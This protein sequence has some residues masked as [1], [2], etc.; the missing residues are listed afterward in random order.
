MSI[1]PI[2]D[3]IEQLSV[4]CYNE[5]NN[6]LRMVGMSSLYE[7]IYDY[8]LN[9]IKE[10]DIK[11]GDKIPTEEEL[12][13]QFQ[14]SRITSKKA[15]DLLSQRDIIQRFQGKGSFVSKNL[16]NF[17]STSSSESTEIKPDAYRKVIGFIIPDFTDTYGLDLVRAIEKRC[18]EL[19]YNLVLKRTFGLEEEEKKAIHSLL[20]IGV[21]GIIILP[22]Q[23]VHYNN[24]LL[25]MVV[26]EYP[27]VLI[28]RYLKR[29]PATSVS[30]DNR[31]AMQELTTLSLDSGH[32]NIAFISPSVDGTSS[33]EERFRGYQAAFSEKGK[34]INQEHVLTE[35]HSTM[36]VHVYSENHNIS[37]EKDRERL[38]QFIQHHPEVTAYVCSEFEIAMLLNELLT[39]MGKK[40]PDD[41]SILCFDSPTFYL[42]EPFFTHIRQDQEAM[43]YQAADL[44]IKQLN[45]ERE[46]HDCK[47]GYRLVPGISTKINHLQGN[48]E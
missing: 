4:N 38:I 27:L 12:A 20:E 2:L 41:I 47:V 45:G 29:I 43:G 18:A 40:V 13:K 44:L 31:K 32:D 9:M 17:D 39:S 22:V 26:E 30:I 14:V 11:S 34:P 8:I 48:H 46:L 28:D 3:S 10:G 5:Y 24:E 16:P 7:Q 21:Q 33:V 19:N 15:L 23:G 37:D 35:I 42:N 1:Y 36:P 25:R 6:L